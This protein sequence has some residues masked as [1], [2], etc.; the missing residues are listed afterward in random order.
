MKYLIFFAAT[1]SAACI[2][3]TGS[4]ILGRDIAQADARYSALPS[5]LIAGF[6]ADPGMK[7][8]F[9]AVELQRLARANGIQIEN[10][11]DIC[12]E[13]PMRQ[14]SKEDAAA[15]MRR[16][17]PAEASL[18]IL[19]IASAQVPAG[20]LE[21]PLDGLEATGLWRGDVKYAETKK[22]P[23]WARVS[24]TAKYSVIVAATD[25]PAGA[26]IAA[27][28]IRIEQKTGPLRHETT[29][30]RLS[31]VEGLAPRQALKAG[32][33]ITAAQ[34]IDPPAVH[35]GDAVRVEVRSGPT[36][37]HFDAIAE[38]SARR[39]DT[40]ELRNPL[41]GK[42]FKARLDSPTTAIIEIPGGH[43]L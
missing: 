19:E 27:S 11:S 29:P 10:P 31:D 21:F 4:R 36:R 5:T 16:Q 24:V 25:L 40:I 6:N 38:A 39:G 23:V 33:P 12:F 7:R 41:N 32:A 3:A 30:A 17:I 28:S 1:A 22:A 34:L 13:F 15:A 43:T 8:I 35:R 18:E 26:P 42:T 2:P 20:E 14:L 37:L 9:T